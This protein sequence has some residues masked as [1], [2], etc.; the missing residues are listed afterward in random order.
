MTGSQSR[1]VES[2]EREEREGGRRGR[3]EREER[4]VGRFPA[5]LTNADQLLALFPG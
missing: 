4:E 5:L 2:E 3:G 1:W